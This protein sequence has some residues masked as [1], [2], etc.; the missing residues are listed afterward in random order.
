[1]GRLVALPDLQQGLAL[2]HS[3]HNVE[4]VELQVCDGVHQRWLPLCP[5]LLLRAAHNS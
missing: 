2:T 4:L 1:M 3:L 5:R